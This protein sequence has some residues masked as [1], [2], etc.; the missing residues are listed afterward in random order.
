VEE[1]LREQE[2]RDERDATRKHSPLQPA[3]DALRVETDGLSVDEVTQRIVGFARA[4]R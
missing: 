4:V 2:Q 1:V 3:G